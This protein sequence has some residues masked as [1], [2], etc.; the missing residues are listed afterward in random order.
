MA[1]TSIHEQEELTPDKYTPPQINT[2]PS[3]ASGQEA[4]PPS[5]TPWGNCISWSFV[6]KPELPVRMNLQS[7]PQL[8]PQMSNVVN[9]CGV[10]LPLTVPVTGLRPGLHAS[11]AKSIP[12]SV[13]KRVVPIPTTNT[14]FNATVSS[15]CVRGELP[16][17]TTSS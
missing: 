15:V 5:G 14:Y 10:T 12:V 7:P 13:I 6:P 17:T 16:L 8:T 9:V 1:M 2:N 11:T 3:T 4:F